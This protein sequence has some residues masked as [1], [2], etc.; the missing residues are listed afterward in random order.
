MMQQMATWERRCQR[1]R[2]YKVS[3][4]DRIVILR[5]SGVY[6]ITDVPEKLFVDKGMWHAGLA[7][8]DEIAQVL[9]TIVYMDPNKTSLYKNVA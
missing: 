5:K 4:L 9:F 8:K 2:T 7:D 1:K 3:P 6:T